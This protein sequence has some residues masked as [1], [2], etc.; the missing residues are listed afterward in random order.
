MA[1]ET[2]KAFIKRIVPDGTVIYVAT[3]FVTKA[4][5]KTFTHKAFKGVNFA[6]DYIDKNHLHDVYIAAQGYKQEKITDRSGRRRPSREAGNVAKIQ[7]FYVDLDAAGRDYDNHREALKALLT[8]IQNAGIP[9]F[10]DLVNTGGGWHVYWRLIEPITVEKWKPIAQA[11]KACLAKHGVKQDTTC[12]A[13]VVRI[14]RVPDTR[15]TKRNTQAIFTWSSGT[16]IDV[17]V[18]YNAV[19]PYMLSAVDTPQTAPMN[20]PLAFSEGTVANSEFGISD[21]AAGERQFYMEN[22][23]RECAVLQYIHETGG[24]NQDEPRWYATLNLAA[25]C[26]D[27]EKYAHE[28]SCGHASYNKLSTQQKLEQAV[29]AKR[30]NSS[31]GPT[32]CKRFEQFDDYKGKCATCS[33]YG[34]FKSPISLGIAGDTV[35][36]SGYRLLN[37]KLEMFDKSEDGSGEWFTLVKQYK[38]HDFKMVEFDG[39]NGM[40]AMTWQ[41][42][43]NKD[44]YT[45]VVPMPQLVDRKQ[46]MQALYGQGMPLD[47]WQAKGFHKFMTTY[48]ELLR[49][50][51]GIEKAS[52]ALGWDRHRGVPGFGLGRTMLLTDGRTVQRSIQSHTKGLVQDYEPAGDPET[53]RQAAQ[54]ILDHGTGAH[55]AI[56]ASAFAAPLMEFVDLSGVIVSATSLASGRGKTTALRVAAAT[57]GHPVRTPFGPNDTANSIMRH[58]GAT[59]SLPS[60]WDEMP[61]DMSK[62][63]PTMFQLTAGREKTRLTASADYIHSQDWKAFLMV[64]SNTS[65]AEAMEAQRGNAGTKRVLEFTVPMFKSVAKIPPVDKHYGHAGRVYAEQ[66]VK[67]HSYLQAMVDK[68]LSIVQHDTGL[69]PADRFWLASIALLQLGAELATRWGIL[70]FDTDGL[71]RFL[72][73]IVGTT[74]AND[75]YNTGINEPIEILHKYFELHAMNALETERM[76]MSRSVG[77]VQPSVGTINKQPTF[78]SFVL[79][80]ND[81]DERV[82]FPCNEFRLFAQKMNNNSKG[83]VD[84]LIENGII[85]YVGQI[86]IPGKHTQTQLRVSCFECDRSKL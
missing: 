70:K 21:P 42:Q 79:W 1:A 83:T 31:L 4:G 81:E 48:A 62:L 7:V 75:S 57:W 47:E 85:Q 76:P 55:A 58:F 24:A 22:I 86:R 51:K 41:C 40:L 25:Y 27:G 78:G 38:L 14:L 33:F 17:N 26:E 64:C 82:R 44:T 56:M 63:S 84:Y 34:E 73:D 16:E 30:K 11:L 36:P 12:T 67:H 46:F 6:V 20:L 54:T 66:L 53:W 80:I 49:T 37:G 29:E 28:L 72:Y 50:S 18:I 68:S 71:R 15:N 5:K 60:F 2:I 10:T 39:P 65:V 8:A 69:K 52:R 9:Q 19:R 3:P 74:T 35:T 23:L 45:I 13:D 43:T 77:G 61:P 59:S 32:T